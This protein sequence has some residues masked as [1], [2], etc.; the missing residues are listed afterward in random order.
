MEFR[1]VWQRIEGLDGQTFHTD[2]GE[3][4]SF[5]FRKTYVVV[6]AGDVSIPRTNFEK[7]FKRM[8]SA[9]GSGTAVVQGQRFITAILS[10]VGIDQKK[11]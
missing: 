3:G 11:A 6:S 9:G 1:D 5:R 7:V 8:Q 10:G 2:R 4:F